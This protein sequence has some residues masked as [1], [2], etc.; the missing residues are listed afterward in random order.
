VNNLLKKVLDEKTW[1]KNMMLTTEE[2]HNINDIIQPGLDNP[3]HPL[4]V[5]AT[6]KDAY[7]TFDDILI[8]IAQLYHN[9]NMRLKKHEKENYALIKNLITTMEDL[10][11]KIIEDVEIS[12]H[13]NVDN[14]LFSSKIS[15]SDRRELARSILQ[16]IKTEESDIFDESG[17]FLSLEDTREVFNP[18]N[19]NPFFRSCGFYRD[20]PDGRFIYVNNS[21]T[22]NL[23]V[24]EE[25]HLKLI[26]RCNFNDKENN[27]IK[28]LL[29]YFDFLDKIHE[30]LNFA[31]DENLGFLTSL[32]NNLGSGCNFN[33]KLLVSKEKGE[34]FEKYFGNIS[35]LSLKLLGQ[36]EDVN[37]YEISNNTTFYNFSKFLLELASMKEIFQ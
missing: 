4:G 29:N 8:N 37:V 22:L 6:S 25:D 13:R 28:F 24:N 33:V 7:F 27:Q 36:K 17:K 12:T 15:R 14:H 31:Y 35:E 30:K 21:N 5:V 23:V 18:N 20:W 26:Q 32:I 3:D 11:N 2:G 19:Q 16:I 1:R 9:R 10:L 34:D